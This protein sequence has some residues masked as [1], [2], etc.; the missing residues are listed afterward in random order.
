MEN[1]LKILIVEDHALIRTAMIEIIKELGKAEIEEA[2]SLKEALHHVSQNDFDLILLDLNLPDSTG[3][4]TLSQFM[5]Q[6]GT[7]PIFV[8]TGIH[9]S[10]LL[11]VL[12]KK[13]ILGVLSKRSPTDRLRLALKTVLEGALWWPE[14][15]QEHSSTLLAEKIANLSIRQLEVLRLCAQGMQNSEIAFRLA[16]SSNTVKSH[17]KNLFQDL[18]L[19]NRVDAANLAGRLGFHVMEKP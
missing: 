14:E 3:L 6:G 19:R 15:D 4:S 1:S 5:E 9:D 18:N 13:P 10:L 2:S 8:L 16:I 11:N 17:L 7:L 12:K